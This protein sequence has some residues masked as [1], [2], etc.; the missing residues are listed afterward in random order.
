VLGLL[1]NRVT[2]QQSFPSRAISLRPTPRLLAELGVL[3]N[4]FNIGRQCRDEPVEPL[5][6]VRFI[7]E[8]DEIE[9]REIARHHRC[10]NATM[11]S[12][13]RLFSEAANVTSLR[14]MPDDTESGLSTN[15]AMSAWTIKSWIRFHRL[16][17]RKCQFDRSAA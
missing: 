1:Q 2:E 15:M 4:P 8:K 12:A 9:T 17:K 11:I 3:A 10:I 13:E 16:R 5:L 6:E 14:Q 7:I